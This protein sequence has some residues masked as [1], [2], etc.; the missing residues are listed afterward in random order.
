MFFYL[1]ELAIFLSFW[2]GKQN[3]FS[4]K[5]YIFITFINTESIQVKL[6]KKQLMRKKFKDKLLVK[7]VGKC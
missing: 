2:K 4:F 7:T 3:T 6:D 1:T 5:S